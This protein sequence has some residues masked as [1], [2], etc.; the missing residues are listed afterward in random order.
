MKR[1]I[2]RSLQTQKQSNLL[3]DV[4]ISLPRIV[5]G[6][7]LAFD[8]GASKFGV[9]W[10]SSELSFLSIPQWFVEDVAN[11]GG[12]F[13]IAPFLFAW[14][15]AASE[16]LGGLLLALG[17]KTRFASVMIA[18]TMLVAILFQKWDQGLWGML[19][20]MGFLWVSLYSLAMGSGRFGLDY[21]LT[22]KIKNA[23]LL[24]I[25]IEKIKRTSSLPKGITSMIVLGTF[26]SC[27]MLSAQERVVEISVDMNNVKEV[28][29]IGLSGNLEPLTWDNS[30]P[31]IDENGDG[32][33]EAKIIFNTSDKY[34]KFKFINNGNLE[35]N[36][37]DSRIL[38]FSDEPLKKSYVFNEYDYYS[39]E[40]ISA[41]T[42]TPEQIREDIQVLSE[43][44]QFLHPAIYNYRDS[45]ALQVDLELLEQEILVNPTQVNTYKAVSKF[46]A[47]IKCSHTF[48][49]PWNQ[50]YGIKRS[51]FFQPDKLPFTF[52]RIGKKLFVDKNASESDGLKAGLEIMSINGIATDSILT[53]LAQ[54]V[55][56]D[57]NNYEKKLERLSLTGTE[58]FSLFDVFYP[59]VFGSAEFFNVELKNHQTSQVSMET[60]KATSKTNRTKVLNE[61]YDNLSTSLRDG[62]NFKLLNDET[63]ILTIKSFAVQRNEFDWKAIIDDAFDQLNE[64]SIPNLIIDI[65]ENEGGQGI[66]GE[67]ILER[68]ITKPLVAPA[69]RASVRYKEIPSEYKKY[70]GTWDKFPYSFTN[71]IAEEIDEKYILKQKYAIAGKTYKPRKDGFKGEVYLITDASNSSAT[72][73][74]AAYAKKIE[75][76]TLVGQTT[77]GNQLGTNGSYMFFLRL[78][79]T[80]IE[81]DIPVINMYVPPISGE[82]RDGGIEP[83]VFVEKSLEDYALG[84]D[85]E[86]K[87]I[88]E[89]IARKQ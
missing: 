43:I 78:P 80:R 32:I 14:L 17:L 86:I 73:L 28:G 19:P 56:S 48:T 62:W 51:L 58:K 53:N 72:H 65:R 15:A 42:F 41:N 45:V 1:F 38:W 22:R 70:I 74:M 85:T 50:G 26:L 57:G 55:T 24:H 76:I 36:G 77:G 5:C 54:Y 87:K 13:A 47:K 8:F 68:V 46:V 20:A 83:D 81:V 69:M 4:L 21:L 33:Y 79:N 31:L 61:R 71:K 25:P 60:I 7:L 35:L 10:S 3:S 27:S 44:V 75:N 88:L 82:S 59:L 16:T 29:G 89:L 40:Q 66:V 12:L 2:E 49:N 39:Q 64:Q 67:Y 52:K 30:Y 11:F 84:Q 6:I 18:S 34:F 37:S 9:P 23:R 63:G